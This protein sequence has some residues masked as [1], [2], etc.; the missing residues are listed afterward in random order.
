MP[1]TH[2]NPLRVVL[3]GP[4]YQGNGNNAKRL[5][6]AAVLRHPPG[7]GWRQLDNQ[8]QRPHCLEG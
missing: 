5:N 6:E 1:H 8:L 7:Y 4:E 2:L 3:V